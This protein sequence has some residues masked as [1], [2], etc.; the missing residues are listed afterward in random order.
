F[1]VLPST[2]ASPRSL[3][4]ALPLST[5]ALLLGDGEVVAH[6]LRTQQILQRFLCRLDGVIQFNRG[7]ELGRVTHALYGALHV[8]HELFHLFVDRKSTRLNSSHAKSSYAVFG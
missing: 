7:Q 5:A 8:I 3:H 6:R 2:S 1:S 4:A